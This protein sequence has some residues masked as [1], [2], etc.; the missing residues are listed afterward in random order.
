MP[1]STQNAAIYHGELMSA[2][3][4]LR[5]LTIPAV[6]GE[7]WAAFA[8]AGMTMPEVLQS[9]DLKALAERIGRA[10]HITAACR[11]FVCDWW[12]RTEEL[13]N[14]VFPFRSPAE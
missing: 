3:K 11:T 4:G 13:L 14:P 7:G 9:E 5:I 1:K 8:N 10:R 12:M 6:Q 2:A